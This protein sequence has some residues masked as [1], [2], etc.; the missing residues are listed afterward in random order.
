MGK[1]VRFQYS[2][3]TVSPKH[4]QVLGTSPIINHFNFPE[5]DIPSYFLKVPKFCTA[6]FFSFY[7]SRTKFL[8]TGYKDKDYYLKF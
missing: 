2:A 8:I 4:Q 5:Q 7:L 6:G 3:A 1:L